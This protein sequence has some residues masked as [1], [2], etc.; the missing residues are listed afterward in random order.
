M[1]LSI[2]FPT[3][4]SHHSRL[5]IK[6]QLDEDIAREI[7]PKIFL[8]EK[9]AQL[10]ATYG[11]E[12]DLEIRNNLIDNAVPTLLTRRAKYF[13]NLEDEEKELKPSSLKEK[14]IDWRRFDSDSSQT[15]EEDEI[16]GFIATLLAQPDKM[17]FENELFQTQEKDNDHPN[18]RDR[19]L[20]IYSV[21]HLE[22]FESIKSQ[23][24]EHE[25]L[26]AQPKVSS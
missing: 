14:T 1:A 25:E 8:E 3:Y 11:I 20:N 12:L 13:A 24:I 26:Q 16:E 5:L 7:A 2:F 10:I 23:L 18:F 21:F 6:T 15:L 4:T 17:V 22:K 9:I 19:I